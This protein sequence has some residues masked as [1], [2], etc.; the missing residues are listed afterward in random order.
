MCLLDCNSDKNAARWHL[1]DVQHTLFFLAAGYITDADLLPS[2]I[3]VLSH[4]ILLT[5]LEGVPQGLCV[6]SLLNLSEFSLQREVVE[7]VKEG[8]MLLLDNPGGL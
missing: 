4:K 1:M 7:R 2:I 6:T 8:I 3:H 5:L